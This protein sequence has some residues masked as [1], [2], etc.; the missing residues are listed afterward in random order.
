MKQAWDAC[1]CSLTKHPVYPLPH[2]GT[3]QQQQAQAVQVPAQTAA[4]MIAQPAAA[5][6]QQQAAGQQ[7]GGGQSS[8]AAAL[9]T[10]SQSQLS[11][12]AGLLGGPGVC[13]V[14]AKVAC[15]E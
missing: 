6:A 11:S 7:Q 8:L 1:T 14:E 12:L 10:L 9:A 15:S 13:A 5:A 4:V 3:Q 2:T